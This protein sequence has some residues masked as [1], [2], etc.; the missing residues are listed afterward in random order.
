VKT[1]Q[2]EDADLREITCWALGQIGPDAKAAVEALRTRLHDEKGKV[3]VE[4]ASSL[5]CIA[6]DRSVIP[7]LIEELK[8]SDEMVCRGAIEALGG[9]GPEAKAAVPALLKLTNYKD[10]FLSE[11]AKESLRCIDPHLVDQGEK[12]GS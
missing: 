7:G 4:A 5:W 11:P 10:R 12:N 9:I 6:Q 8:G 2:D 3:R 1:L